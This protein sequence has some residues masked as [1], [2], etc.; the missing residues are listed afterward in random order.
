[1][2]GGSAHARTITDRPLAN[3]SI[4]GLKLLDQAFLLNVS[5]AKFGVVLEPPG[6]A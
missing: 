3:L 5:A 4:G 2:K 1:M 6:S